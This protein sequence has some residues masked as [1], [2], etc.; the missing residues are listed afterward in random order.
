MQVLT[1]GQDK[2]RGKECLSECR[3]RMATN[4]SL[5]DNSLADSPID[6]KGSSE[7]SLELARTLTRAI[8]EINVDIE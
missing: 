1:V 3:V 7:T 8:A 2:P 4:C 6:L 5:A